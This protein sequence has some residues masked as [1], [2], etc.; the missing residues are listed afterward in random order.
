MRSWASGMST[1]SL[2]TWSRRCVHLTTDLRPVRPCY[3]VNM[4]HLHD[5]V[6]RHCW[7]MHEQNLLVVQSLLH[8][9]AS[10]QG[11]RCFLGFL[12]AIPP[13]NGILYS[14]HI[15]CLHAGNQVRGGVRMGLQVRSPSLLSRAECMMASYPC[16]LAYSSQSISFSYNP[17][18]C[19][20]SI[21]LACHA[22]EGL[23][24]WGLGP[25]HV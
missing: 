25:S 2:T 24:F 5:A 20:E 15:C 9:C 17:V 18:I 22:R 12:E 16:V 8:C 11:F 6:I 19:P 3:D 13:G 7:D 10:C 4:L 1:G 21:A 14:T 23:G